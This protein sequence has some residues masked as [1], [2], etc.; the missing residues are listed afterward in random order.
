VVLRAGRS[1]MLLDVQ[2]P[3]AREVGCESRAVPP[4]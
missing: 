3:V 4:L 1:G 2:R